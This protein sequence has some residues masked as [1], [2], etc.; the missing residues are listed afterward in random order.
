MV[1]VMDIA[2]EVRWGVGHRPAQ[3]GADPARIG[4]LDPVLNREDEKDGR[5]RDAHDELEDLHCPHARRPADEKLQDPAADMLPGAGDVDKPQKIDPEPQQHRNLFDPQKRGDEDVA[6]DDLN[7]HQEGERQA[8]EDDERPFD[9][10]QELQY[11]AH[12]RPPRTA[13][14]APRRPTRDGIGVPRPLSRPPSLTGAGRCGIDTGSLIARCRSR[15]EGR[16]GLAPS[17]VPVRRAPGPSSP[18]RPAPR[19]TA[20][21]SRR[22]SSWPPPTR[23]RSGNEPACRPLPSSRW[24]RRR[25]P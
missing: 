10:N 19:P 24:R 25:S 21:R 9:S 18:C 4:R 11:C 14:T 15:I 5:A 12:A 6:E 1:Y 16:D 2:P 17:T 23:H 3:I 13:H 20:T 7:H 8:K 22:R